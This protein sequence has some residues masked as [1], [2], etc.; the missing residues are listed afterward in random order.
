M[1]KA[2]TLAEVLVTLSIIGVVATLTMPN[3]MKGWQ[4][5]SYVAQLRKAYTELSQAMEQSMTD[6]FVNEVWM[7][8]AM[9]QGP[10][11]FLKTYFKTIET[12]DANDAAGKCLADSYS[13][14]KGESITIRDVLSNDDCACAIVASGYSICIQDQNVLY[15]TLDI[16]GKQGPNVLGRDLFG[17]YLDVDGSVYYGGSDISNIDADECRGDTDVYN[18]LC[19]D[20]IVGD[21]WSMDY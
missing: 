19:F 16:N 11:T 4:N 5:R 1:K 15:V 13:N 8:K 14:I 20:K 9:R 10:E 21:G 3:F 17:I 2:F 7:T 6:S 12:C 18:A